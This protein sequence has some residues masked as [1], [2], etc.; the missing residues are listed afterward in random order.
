MSSGR[1]AEDC[2]GELLHLAGELLGGAFDRAEPGDGELRG[3]GAREAGSRVPVRVVARPDVDVVGRAAEDLRDDLR[4]RRLVSL[5]LRHRAERHHDLAE[6]VELDRR[7]LVVAGELQLRVEDHRLAEVVRSGV[8]R[9]ADADPEE[10]PARLRVAPLLV[11]RVVADQ[12]ERDVEAA[13]VVA[14][15]VDAAVRR[16]VGELF[17]LDVVLLAHLDRIEAELVR[18]DVDDPLGQP[19][20][21]H[22]RVAA[23][24]RDG[25]LVRADLREVDAD[26]APPVAAGRHLRPDD[27]AERLVARE[28]PAVVDRLD[29][30]PEH[31]AVGLHRDGHVEEGALVPVRVRR[32][33]V[34]APL[35]PLHGTVEL[36]GEEAARGVLG[37]KRDLV[38]EAAADVLADEAQLVDADTQRR[39]H[40]DRADAGHLV[41]AV[42]RPLPRAA[43][44]LDEAAGALE[45]CGR[46]AVEVQPLDA[47]DMVGVGERSVEVAPVEH[48]RPDGVRAGIFVEDDLVLQR[49]LAV[50]HVRHR[51]VVDLDQLGSVP[52]ELAGPRDDRRDG[53]ADVAHAADGERVV[54]D[55]RPGGRRKLEERIGEDRDLVARERSV[56]TVELERLRDVD[57]LDAGV[58]VRRAHE[59]DEPHLVP[60]DVV[61]EHALALDE[62]LVLLARNVLADEAG[63]RLA[64]LDDEGTLGSDS[65]LG[66]C[67]A[68]LIASTMFT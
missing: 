58:R 31:R 25:R 16:L 9:G 13:G 52:R 54:L 20:V 55:V 67:A 57:R 46:K 66:H 62:P 4:R 7:D 17:V 65:R 33:L 53:V 40:P 14:G 32:V 27:A 2:R 24:R 48:S 47:H 6:D 30:E 19:E 60:L 44:E 64:L 35:R 1:A 41:V 28:S 45:R 63:L 36:P 11:Q 51:V 23:V 68:A 56:D 37:M 29:G 5:P 26:V 18:D 50:E 49:L 42:D 43:V 12:V 61:E 8:E 59:V 21:L 10:L 39:C 15:V 3:V 34:R 38:A 22:A